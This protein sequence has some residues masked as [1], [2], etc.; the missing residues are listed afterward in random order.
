MTKAK[1]MR[2]DQKGGIRP[3]G[4]KGKA[5]CSK[6]EDWWQQAVE[7]KRAEEDDKGDT[8]V[9]CWISPNQNHPRKCCMS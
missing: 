7:E 5:E 9:E 1:M 2:E 8:W 4:K 6:R 3:L